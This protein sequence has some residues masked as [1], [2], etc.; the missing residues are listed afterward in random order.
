MFARGIV[1]RENA[2]DVGEVQKGFAGFVVDEVGETEAVR[3]LM[4]HDVQQIDLIRTY[5]VVKSV[6]STCT[7]QATW[8]AVYIAIKE[9]HDIVAEW[10]NKQV[11]VTIVSISRRQISIVQLVGQGNVIPGVWIE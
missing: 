4:H 3:E 8:V 5:V 11:I 2:V 7:A 9:C 6:I 10:L 1:S